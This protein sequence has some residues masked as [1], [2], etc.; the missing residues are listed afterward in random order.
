M[1][2]Q[3]QRRVYFI[4]AAIVLAGVM[5][6]QSRG[7]LGWGVWNSSGVQTVMA[8]NVDS[9]RNRLASVPQTS[10]ADLVSAV[11]PAVVTI[12]SARR[13]RA[14]QQYPFMDDPLFQQ[15]FGNRA[16]NGGRGRNNQNRGGGG[17]DMQL[18]RAL[19]SGVIVNADGHILTN[20][21]VVDGADEITVELPD[22]STVQAKLVG[23]DAPSDLAVLKI[24]SSSK[25]PVLPLG[26][27]DKTRVGDV[28][29]AIGNPLGVGQTVTMGIIS[30]KERSTGLS[31]GSF[32]D[33]LQTDAAINQGNSGGAL[34]NTQ[35]QLIGINSQILSPSGGNIGIGF[36]IPSNMAKNVMGQLVS[37]GKVRRG[38][39]GV[40]I[41]A[42]N[43]DIAASLGLKDLNGVLVNSVTPG[44]A[45]EKAGLKQGDIIRTFN[46]T[47]VND[48]NV[49]RNMVA[50]SGPNTDVNLGILR[51]GREQTVKVHLGEFKPTDTAADE[52]SG[53]SGGTSGHGARL[54]IG[55][56]PLTPDLAQRFSIPANVN[57]L[58]VTEVD[59][60]GPAAE[61]G[62]AAGDVVLEANRRK[63]G[64][65]T[66]LSAAVNAAGDRPVLLLVNRG[67]QSIYLTVRPKRSS[68]LQ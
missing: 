25:L 46:G 4:L 51:D 37:G 58:V 28:V 47:T 54:G 65:A 5:L 24:T 57:G 34:V 64:S 14:P 48:T 42:I 33:F 32:E 29:L 59:P 16:P 43:S 22:R 17:G 27:S 52:N 50:Q 35:G 19:G 62:I 7:S 8:Q 12:R 63:V 18:E 67:G 39:I 1:S 11:A 30:A 31:N 20:H 3:V 26:D 23:S 45:G 9:S 61:A 56:Q 2:T 49:L 15:F 55:V 41:Q 44:G 66:D 21:H 53:P 40:G 36:A 13:V 10:Y 60:V 6:Y 68:N 38:Q